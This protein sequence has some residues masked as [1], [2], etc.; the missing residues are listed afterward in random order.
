MKHKYEKR[1]WYCGSQDMAEMD[2]YSECRECHATWTPTS[3]L[4]PNPI[5]LQPDPMLSLRSQQDTKSPSPSDSV[6]RRARKA[7]EVGA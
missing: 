2:S 7:R 1:C 5:T 6:V 4:E 3:H